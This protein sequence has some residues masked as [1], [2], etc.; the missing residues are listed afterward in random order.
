MEMRGIYMID[1]TGIKCPVCDV[2]FNEKD[3]IVV[4]A[5]CGA[6]YHRNCYTEKGDCVFDELHKSGEAWKVPVEKK[7]ETEGTASTRYEIKDKEC[8]SC[9]VLNAHSNLFCG[10][11]GVNLSDETKKY[12]NDAYRN[13]YQD[14]SY[15]SGQIPMSGATMPFKVDAM[16][17]TN[18]SETVTD[19]ITFGEMSKVVQQNT[20]YYLS[21]FNRIKEFGKS[22]FNFSAFLFSGAWMLYRKQYKLGIFTTVIMFA[23]FIAQT[24][25]SIFVSSPLLVSKADQLGIDI[26]TLSMDTAMIT[27]LSDNLTM[28]ELLIIS[29]PFFAMMIMFTIMLFCGFLANRMYMKSCIKKI[30][31]TKEVTLN[32]QD[33]NAKIMEKGG[34]NTAAI[35]CIIIC[36]LIA[37]NLPIY[38]LK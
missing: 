2:V 4:C 35:L 18:P 19:G 13:S 20:A 16:G 7:E 17:G 34:V 29:L 1:Y 3:D 33:Y 22:K 15:S 28:D 11:C 9:G 37:S 5:K 10:S 8:P 30:K 25:L 32:V 12:K 36:Y 21:I 6:P 31:E 38:L 14:S 27:F 24:F 23:L 26:E